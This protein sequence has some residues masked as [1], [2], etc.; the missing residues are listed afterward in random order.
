MGKFIKT[1]YTG[2]GIFRT[3][4]VRYFEGMDHGVVSVLPNAD[5]LGLSQHQE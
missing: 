5:L 2:L 4:T 3:K 1:I